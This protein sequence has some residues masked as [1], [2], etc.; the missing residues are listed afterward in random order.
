ML[1][2]IFRLFISIMRSFI[3]IQNNVGESEF[4][5]LTPFVQ[6]IITRTGEQ[7]IPCGDHVNCFV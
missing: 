5:C 3:K 6:S 7:G 4:P 1:M 2:P